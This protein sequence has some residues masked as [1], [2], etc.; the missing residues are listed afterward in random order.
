MENMTDR[1]KEI[2]GEVDESYIG[3]IVSFP[4]PDV[5]FEH[6]GRVIDVS[7]CGTSYYVFV[8]NKYHAFSSRHFWFSARNVSLQPA[9]L[10]Y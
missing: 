6:I 9:N 5:E 3:K 8:K 1:L 2:Y 10:Q 4:R 7:K